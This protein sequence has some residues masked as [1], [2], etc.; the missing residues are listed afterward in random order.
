MSRKINKPED[1][2]PTP[3]QIWPDDETTTDMVTMRQCAQIAKAYAYECIG[4]LK[5]FPSIKHTKAVE[6]WESKFREWE[7]QE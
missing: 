5:N 4:L 2:Q 7:K 6:E 3:I 1:V